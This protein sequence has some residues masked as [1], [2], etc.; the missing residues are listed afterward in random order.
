MK[1]Y[2]VTAIGTDSGK[3]F[4]SAIIC[5]A[6][7][8]DYWKPIQ[9]GTPTDAETV[10]N[11]VTNEYSLVHPTQFLLKTPTSPHIAAKIENRTLK[12]K[13]FVLP[14]TDN[15]LII[16]GA[17]GILVPVNNDGEMIIDLANKFNCEVILV[18][19]LYLGC[20]NHSLLSL[21]ELKRRKCNLKGI[22]FNG[23][24]YSEAKEIILKTAKVPELLHIEKEE[25][26]NDFVIKTYSI[27]LIE[28]WYE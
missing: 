2:F 28:K 1:N 26:I 19:N 16:E 24:E 3:T 9:C 12:I 23:S 20:I 6:L 10:E 27:A 8:A 17:G 18:I 25:Q 7:Q 15:N 4:V 13:D 11:L 21:E 22:V 14:I 5:D